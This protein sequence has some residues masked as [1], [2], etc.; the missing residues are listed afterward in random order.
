MDKIELEKLDLEAF[1]NWLSSYYL[2]RREKYNSSN[3]YK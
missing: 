2:I 1:M 3:K